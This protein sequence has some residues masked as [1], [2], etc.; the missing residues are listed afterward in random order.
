MIAAELLID[1]LF[2]WIATY[3]IHSTLLLA[4]CWIFVRVA[5]TSSHVLVERAWKI[6][7]ISGILTTSLQLA[8]VS[9]PLLRID[10]V[11]AGAPQNVLEPSPG[12]LSQHP[13]VPRSSQKT[14]W[15]V[16]ATVGPVLTVP[17]WQSQPG[18]EIENRQSEQAVQAQAVLKS[19]SQ[20]QQPAH[21]R[22]RVL[23]AVVSI[24]LATWMIIGLA[25]IAVCY[26]R[27]C[28]SLR[29]WRSV[30]EGTVRRLL[31]DLLRQN[32]IRRRVDLKIAAQQADPIATGVLRWTIV[33]PEVFEDSLSQDEQRAALMHELAHL[34]RRDVI[35]LWIGG[36]LATCLGFQPLN[37]IARRNWQRASEYLCDQWAVQRGVRPL[38]LAK[39]LTALAGLRIG[40]DAG[41][42]A[43]AATGNK[44]TLA[45]RI[46]RLLGH[47]PITDPWQ[48]R[49]RMCLLW[50]G[51]AS[52]VALT[53]LL[54]PGIRAADD[55][56]DPLSNQP[57][58]RSADDEQ[59][60][61]LSRQLGP[62]EPS[63]KSQ[64]L[65]QLD[66][67]LHALASELDDLTRTVRQDE[68]SGQVKQML[69]TIRQATTSLEQQRH[70]LLMTH[71]NGEQE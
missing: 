50:I 31:D 4:G 71:L 60:S 52:L 20:V 29:Q 1:S 37:F 25:R 3:L 28:F 43:L 54:A 27:L 38:I 35:W 46:K 47:D 42:F 53:S 23:R 13:T 19:Y 6:A 59:P 11:S 58:H 55:Y 24:S 51:A 57:V 17:S 36:L 8:L 65:A 32:G 56:A 30:S 2:A 40:R 33:V 66:L 12:T 49:S 64:S 63:N 18:L 48:S 7:A 68:Q 5:R 15:T 41:T 22:A 26:A 39:C 45:E 61:D 14:E 34:V 69:E 70:R 10:F 16:Q 21:S 67:E 44:R 9:F 62:N